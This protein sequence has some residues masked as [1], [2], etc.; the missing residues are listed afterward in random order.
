MLWQG[1]A[2][3]PLEAALTLARCGIPVCP[4]HYPRVDGSGWVASMVCSC[5]R[6]QCLQ[7]C[8][9]PL[10]PE[11]LAAATTDPERIRLWWQATPDANVGLVTG[12]VC[13]VIDTDPDTG[14][15][16]FRVLA[17]RPT[18]LGPVARTGTGRWLFFTAPSGRPGAVLADGD[19]GI[20]RP[21]PLVRWRGLDSSVLA[22]P[23]R[24]LL[25]NAARWARPFATELPDPYELAQ[26]LTDAVTAPDDFDEDSGRLSRLFAPVRRARSRV[27]LG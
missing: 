21:G 15:R 27:V 24:T 22:P 4:F 12:V 1:A 19:D 11:G 18:G 5:D 8:A 13:D 6:P 16:A 23:S 7:P 20:A 17:R 14:R 2:Y 3:S 9:H 25:G 26:V 10:P